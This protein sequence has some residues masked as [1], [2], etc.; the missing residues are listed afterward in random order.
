MIQDTG[1]R[2]V[3]S[4]GAESDIYEGKG[5]CDLI[6]FKVL[7]AYYIYLSR[8]VSDEHASRCYM[9]AQ[10]LMELQDY[11]DS[12]SYNCLHNALC[13]FSMTYPNIGCI[14]NTAEMF[15]EVSKHYE[16]GAKKYAERNW[17]KGIP[18]SAMLDSCVRHLIK[19]VDGWTDE[20]HD[21]AI[22]W[23]LLG[24]LHMEMN[25]ADNPEICDIKHERKEKA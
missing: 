16:D 21:R 1:N 2:K 9:A 23:R 14:Y 19:W 15:I 8:K 7:S 10:I 13:A 11:L 24:L 25:F 12:G 20:P 18:C 3:F 4:T 5:R 22:V 17:E 6:P